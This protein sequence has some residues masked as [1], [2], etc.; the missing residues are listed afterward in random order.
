MTLYILE[1]WNGYAFADRD[2]FWLGAYS[3]PEK[4]TEARL[5]YETHKDEW[6][7]NGLKQGEFVMREAVLDRDGLFAEEKE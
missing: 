3:S 7:F 2:I 1:W 5:R 4:R 6:P